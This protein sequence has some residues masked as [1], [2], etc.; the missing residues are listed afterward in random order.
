M[1]Y[2]FIKR[3][4]LVDAFLFIL[5][6]FCQ[7]QKR[8]RQI[9]TAFYHWKTKSYISD[10]EKKS[11]D[12]LA[13]KTIYKRIFDVDWNDEAHFPEPIS[14][15][16]NFKLNGLKII[17]TVF[18]T[19][20]T[21]VRLADN[22]LDTFVSVFL[23]K[24]LEN[25]ERSDIPIAFGTEGPPFDEIQVDCDWTQTTRDK[26][27]L[28]LKKLKKISQ[29]TLSATI[30]LHQIKDKN[31][32]GVPPVD[33]GMLMVYNMGNLDDAK[34]E[35]SILDINVLKS[36]GSNLKSYNLKLDIALPIFSW[37]VVLRD[38]AVVRLINGLIEDDFFPS[39]EQQNF[40]PLP[41]KKIGESR[42]EL[43]EN[44]YFKGFYLY[45]NDEIRIENT[46]LSILTETTD[47]LAQNIDNQ[48][49]TIA[50]YHLDSVLL[51]RYTWVD[52]GGLVGKFK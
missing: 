33:K 45:K 29:K 36:Y 37:G 28:F 21:F 19:N 50:F 1:K 4:K 12:S 40:V 15:A 2:L 23:K 10:F 27:F 49:L 11:L 22:Q 48:P 31:V 47:F 14:I 42:F 26:F 20:K 35:N 30:R 51:K 46:P 24:I 52:L 38:G 18:I 5:I 43:L 32:M 44:M 41:I 3:I 9:T 6:F 25:M 34:T 39:C 16:Q 13:T 17:P 8:E 7:C